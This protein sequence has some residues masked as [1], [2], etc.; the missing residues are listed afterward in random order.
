MSRPQVADKLATP[1]RFGLI[2]LRT[3]IFE[4]HW[5]N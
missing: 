5:L 2:D 1:L 4:L 3:S